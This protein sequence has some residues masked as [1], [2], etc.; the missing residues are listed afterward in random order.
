M[1]IIRCHQLG[2]V[3]DCAQGASRIR[4]TRVTSLPEFFDKFGLGIDAG[5]GNNPYFSVQ[6]EGLILVLGLKRG[7]EQRVAKAHVPIYPGL[8]CVRATEGE[9]I[10]HPLE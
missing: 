10:G 8:L 5:V 3:L 7:F 9:R 6:R 1:A 4:R 2:E